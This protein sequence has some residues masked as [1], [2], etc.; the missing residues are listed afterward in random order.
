MEQAICNFLETEKWKWK[1]TVRRGIHEEKTLEE[2]L[3]KPALFIT[4][5]KP[6]SEEQTEM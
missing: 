2:K 1:K 5:L 4:R 6:T 3:D